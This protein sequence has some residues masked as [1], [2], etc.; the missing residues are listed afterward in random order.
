M[1]IDPRLTTL[2]WVGLAV[3]VLSFLLSWLLGVSA[4]SVGK[5]IGGMLLV[6]IFLGWA[7]DVTVTY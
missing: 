6:G 1:A 5:A 2:A 4:L 3:A 7:L